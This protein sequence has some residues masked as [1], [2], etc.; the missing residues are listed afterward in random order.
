[1]KKACVLIVDDE[2]DMLETC[3]NVL[4]SENL[5]VRTEPSAAAAARRLGD[6]RFDLLITDITMPEMN[7]M[8]LLERVRSASP[9]TVVIMLT[10]FPTVETA[11]DSV[12]Q[13]AFDYITKPFTPDQL[14]VAVSRALAHR[15]LK[16]ENVL[17]S[18]EV[19][20]TARFDALIGRSPK[21]RAVFKLIEQVSSSDSD[22]LILGESGTGKE[23]IA[24]SLHTR[25]RRR[26]NRLVPVDCG[27]IP[28]NLLENELSGHERGAFTGAQTSSLGLLDLAHRGTLFLDEICELPAS[29]QAKLLRV[30]QER[31]FRRVGGRD[32][33]DVDIQVI[34][35][36]NRDIETEVREKRFREDLFYRVNVV[37]IEV[38]PLRERAEDV[39]LLAAHFLERY[40]K[41]WGN[42]DRPSG[43]RT[44][45]GCV[46]S[47]EKDAMEVLCRY[48]W[49]GN[50]RELQNVIQRAM[51]VCRSD[52]IAVADLPA[53]VFESGT[54]SSTPGGFFAFRNTRLAAFEG[55]YLRELLTRHTGDVAMAAEE[56]R[57]PRG[58]LYRLLKKHG[59][60][61]ESFRN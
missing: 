58:T 27:A 10:A 61:P 19:E 54:P 53:E 1:M 50:V 45:H 14:R 59:L 24:R 43:S 26:E 2:P 48:S 34:A 51:V 12:K 18:R 37:R 28:D 52:Q 44:L 15:R 41:K 17:L 38:P 47:I 29:L 40:A 5:D 31:Q 7:G 3:A 32:L 60:R 8:E 55:D 42:S 36:T 11:V 22:V 25:G 49:P 57:L 23:L 35:A 9:E 6:E 13:G 16:E 33:I 20:R 4:G 46:R 21:M 56:A 39:P 30:L